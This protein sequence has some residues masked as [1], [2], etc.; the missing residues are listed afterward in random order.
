MEPWASP[1][2][3]R[4]AATRLA[5]AGID[6][7]LREAR[8][9]SREA[10]GLD[11]FEDFVHRRAAREPFCYIIGRRE[12]WSLDFEVTPAVLIPRPDSETLVEAALKEFGATPPARLIDLGTGSGCLIISL[13]SEWREATGVAVDISPA[14]LDV[15]RS[16][17]GRLG[18]AARMTFDCR[19][20]ATACGERF[21][22]VVSNPPYIAD[23][24]IET[25]EPDVRAF[26]P[27][28]ALSGGADGLEAYRQL[29]RTLPGLLLPQGRAFLE[30]GFDQAESVIGILENQ[31]LRVIRIVKDLAGHDRVVAARLPG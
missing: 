14:A 31:G 9:L 30:I 10:N 19:D 21:D 15:A 22:L 26:E 23:S 20:F 17:A 12:F 18:T 13:L 11:Q 28:L 4:A 7:A 2:I 27:I 8:L 16:N 25:L 29:A 24:V 1:E 3:L 5:S 6:D